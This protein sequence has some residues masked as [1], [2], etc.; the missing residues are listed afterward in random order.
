MYCKKHPLGRRPLE[1]KHPK[2]MIDTIGID[3]VGIDPSPI[4]HSY[5]NIYIYM[6]MCMLFLLI[7]GNRFNKNL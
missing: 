5:E 3:S 1:E 2:P 7:N 4:M 6:C